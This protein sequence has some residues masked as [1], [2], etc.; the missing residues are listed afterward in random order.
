[1][2]GLLVIP[3]VLIVMSLGQKDTDSAWE[4]LFLIIGLPI[5]ILNAWEWFMSNVAEAL[6]GKR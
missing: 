6:F 3:L 2:L 1:L 5:L 4:L